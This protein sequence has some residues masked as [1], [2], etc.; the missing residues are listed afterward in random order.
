MAL[1]LAVA[2][3]QW[4]GNVFGPPISWDLE[5]AEAFDVLWG[6]VEPEAVRSAVRVSADLP[7]HHDWLAEYA[8]LGFDDL[9]LHHVGQDQAE[10]I[11]AFGE[12]VL[13]TLREEIR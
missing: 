13:P 3:D 8:D 6:Q 9:Y 7:Q 5:T 12:L 10:F 11:E 2:H 4:A 1:A